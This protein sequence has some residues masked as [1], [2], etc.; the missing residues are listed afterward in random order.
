MNKRTLFSDKK[1]TLIDFGVILLISAIFFAVIEIRFPYFFLNDD[2][3]DS[4]LCVY[5]H[6]VRSVLS[7][8]FPFYNFH[9]FCGSRFFGT[10]QTG[11]LNP[12]VY[13][14]AFIS[15]IIFGHF[16]AT[17]DIMAFF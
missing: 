14:S 11:S 5:K 15:T 16:D 4:Y 7:G 3:A 9:Q 2:N 12:L 10:G 6:S 8:E 13:L 1:Q 17:I